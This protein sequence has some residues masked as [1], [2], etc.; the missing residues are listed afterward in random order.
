V[1]PAVAS[2]VVRT[3]ARALQALTRGLLFPSESDYPYRA[4]AAPF[5]REAALT[6]DTFRTAAGIGRRFEITVKSAEQ[7]F[8]QR[9]HPIDDDDGDVPKYVLLKKVMEATLTELSLIR[10]GGER[11]VR[12]RV[13]LVG[14]A[15][16]G[17]LS[18]LSTVSIET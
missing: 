13:F 1:P 17:N 11:V 10:V 2:D 18:G 3:L 16:D 7:F 8:E 5:G 9:I 15:D 14:K 12:V 6:A 4:F